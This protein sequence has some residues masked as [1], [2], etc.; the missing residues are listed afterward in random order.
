MSQ[1]QEWLQIVAKDA[2]ELEKAP[3]ELKSDRD[4][5][6]A[7]VAQK[8]MALQ[9]AAEELKSDREIALKAVAQNGQALQHVAEG[10]KSD[11]EVITAAVQQDA[12]YALMYAA[13]SL[14]LDENFAV[15]ARANNYIFK[16]TAISGRSCVMA[17]PE[18]LGIRGDMVIKE[19]LKRLGLQ[20]SDSTKLL[21]GTDVVPNGPLDSKSPG[22]PSPGKLVEYQ[23]IN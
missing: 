13:E 12:H 9:C 10:L 18:F 8:G 6:L 17:H 21:F 20:S 5:V 23:L 2:F 11:R 7:A 22:S 16:V 1:K 14:L 3:A 19:S 4:V 15:D